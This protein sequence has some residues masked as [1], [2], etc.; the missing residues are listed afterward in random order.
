M[1]S[2]LTAYVPIL[3]CYSVSAQLCATV[4]C[5]LLPNDV[6]V[7]LERTASS[8]MKFHG[9]TIGTNSLLCTKYEMN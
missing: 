1:P 2:L 9:E 7:L 4:E 6:D 3:F 5:N 8:Q